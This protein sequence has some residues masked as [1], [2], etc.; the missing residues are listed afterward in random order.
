MALYESGT[1]TGIMN[2]LAIHNMHGR[3]FPTMMQDETQSLSFVVI[4]IF[5][6]V[7]QNRGE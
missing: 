3:S 7:E 1:L 6:C 2:C 5:S 4:L